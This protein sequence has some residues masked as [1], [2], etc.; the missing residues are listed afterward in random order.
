MF[1]N[2]TKEGLNNV[3][4]KNVAILRKK[5]KLSQ[6]QLA[7]KLQ[8]IGLDVDKNAIQRIECGKRFVT[9]IELIALVN[10][11]NTEYESL[12]K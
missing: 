12:L 2:K 10:V 8:L 9:D 1:I 11:L 6:R 3:C 5:Q 7:D 4:G